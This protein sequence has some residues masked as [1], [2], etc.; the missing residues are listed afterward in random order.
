MFINPGIYTSLI[1]EDLT[2]YDIL[3]NLNLELRD[4]VDLVVKYNL[5]NLSRKFIGVYITPQ[6]MDQIQNYLDGFCMELQSRLG[7]PLKL[8]AQVDRAGINNSQVIV[9]FPNIEQYLNQF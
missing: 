6:V 2:I 8:K 9:Q 1:P 4:R 7:K 5:D 3:S